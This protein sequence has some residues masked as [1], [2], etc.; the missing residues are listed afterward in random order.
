MKK[1]LPLLAVVVVAYLPLLAGDIPRPSDLTA[2]RVEGGIRISFL[3]ALPAGSVQIERSLYG[4]KDA[5]FLLFPGALGKSQ[6]EGKAE[7][8]TWIDSSAEPTVGPYKYRVRWK[9]G[10]KTGP[11]SPKVKETSTAG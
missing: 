9:V 7:Y 4:K 5:S 3:N 2:K 6:V 11:W 1:L 8:S 10:D